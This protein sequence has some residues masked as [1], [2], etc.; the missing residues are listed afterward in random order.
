VRARELAADLALALN[1]GREL[2]EELR[3]VR[4]ECERLREDNEHLRAVLT[5]RGTK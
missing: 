1:V 5:A 4:A 2:L 3:A